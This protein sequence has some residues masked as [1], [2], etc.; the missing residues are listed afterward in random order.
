[1]I[2]DSLSGNPLLTLFVVVGGGFLVGR[3]R[4]GGFSL[5]VAGVLFTG[6][7]LGAL[8]ARLKLPEIVYL[9]GLGLF[10]YTMGLSAGPGFV[11]SLRRAGLRWNAF[12]LA[13]IAGVAVL[14]VA[15]SWLLDLGRAKGAGFFTGVLTNTPALAGVV[16][17]LDGGPDANLPVV[18]YSLAY[19]VSVLACLVGISVLQ[20][21]W[22][23]DYAAEARAAHLTEQPIHNATA[24]VRRPV[25][26]KDVVRATGGRA[27][28][29]RVAHAGEVTVAEPDLRLCPGD[30]VTIVGERDA[31]ADATAIVG[32]AAPERL[33]TD[34]SRLDVRRIFVSD[35]DLVG[36]RIKELDL[37]R[38]FGATITRVRRGDTDSLADLNTVLELGDRVR[39]LA[40]PTRMKEISRYFGD[41]YKELGEV[42]IA[43]LSLG[44]ALGLLLGTVSLPLP[45]GG[46]LSLGF[47][48]GPLVVGLL[49][50]ARRRI[51][52]LVWQLPN[53]V[54]WSLRQMGLVLF[55]AGIGTRAGQ[56]FVATVATGDG[57]KLVAAAFVVCLLVTVGVLWLGHR[58]L[59][60]PMG[61]ATGVLAAVCT[62][63]ATLGFAVEQADNELPERAYAAVY[64]TA[65]IVKILLAQILLT[66]L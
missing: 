62:Q 59:R 49:L 24:D 26:V 16:E 43:S 41:S 54:N 38:R 17:R 47:A 39:V 56:S 28:I 12:A 46:Q 58:V 18:A 42:N 33:D 27:L 5:G 48:G 32:E 37:A 53:N 3:V 21:A 60:W 45:G 8:D 9:L 61:V 66:V 35:P 25:T 4:I 2:V 63:P 22:G 30:R 44:L 31:I 34:R 6:I 20:R 50:G 57:A 40:P 23:V 19:P 65:M 10:V 1:M 51:G 64:P 13:A 55:L 29:G 52:P 15:L 14:V 7:A 36:R 11:G